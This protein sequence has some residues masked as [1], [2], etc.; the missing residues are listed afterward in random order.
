MSRAR[1]N[2]AA[3]RRRS[4]PRPIHPADEPE[5][6]NENAGFSAVSNAA[7]GDLMAPCIKRLPEAGDFSALRKRLRDPSITLTML[8]REWLARQLQAAAPGRRKKAQ[9][10]LLCWW[11]QNAE[12]MARKEAVARVCDV[13]GKPPTAK[14]MEA[15][16]RAIRRAGGDA[17]D[18]GEWW[19]QRAQWWREG[20]RGPAILPPALARQIPDFAAFLRDRTE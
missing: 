6:P 2:L 8:E 13:L 20:S 3:V 4:R 12:G 10:P 11:F 17:Y 19:R 14:G 16:E 7:G 18:P 1:V 15:V 9:E 5:N